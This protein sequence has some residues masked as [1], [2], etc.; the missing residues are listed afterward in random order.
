MPSVSVVMSVFNGADVVQEAIASIREQT[1]S[2][3]EFIIVDD[4]S[5]DAT[6]E[7][8]RRAAIEDPRIVLLQHDNQ[9]L[10]RSLNRGVRAAR[11]ELVARQDADDLS[12]PERLARQVAFMD[13]NRHVLLLGTAAYDGTITGR[14]LARLPERSL[15]G[16]SVFLHNPFAHTSAM[17]RRT[18][19]QELGGYDE[20]FDTSQDF[21]L[22]MRFA[23]RGAISMLEEPLVVRR[24]QEQ[25]ISRKKRLRQLRNGLRARLMHPGCG[26]LAA[27]G[28]TAYQGL[29]GSAP[30]W[31]VAVVR[32]AKGR[33]PEASEVPRGGRK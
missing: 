29:S 23:E 12:L 28:A 7:I 1:F 13:A 18:D 27:L 10:T 16:E 26:V 17:F 24:L 4:G 19:W 9:G 30:D 15:L 33:R 25:S 20:S 21:E 8:L 32:A 6:P 5:R 2:D 11:A 3:F 14:T 22:W 31:L